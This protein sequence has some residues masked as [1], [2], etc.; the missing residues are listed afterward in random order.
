MGEIFLAGRILVGGYYL[1]SAAHHFA[2]LGRWPSTPPRWAFHS[3]RWRWPWR[4]SCSRS[5][6]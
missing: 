1:L 3:L 4:A 2:D 6:A 5:P